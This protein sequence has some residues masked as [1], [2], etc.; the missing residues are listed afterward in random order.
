MVEVCQAS[1]HFVIPNVKDLT[2][3]VSH[4]TFQSLGYVTSELS[5]EK[6]ISYGASEMT[7]ETCK[8]V[9]MIEKNIARCIQIYMYVGIP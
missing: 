7:L 2:S 8:N 6:Q 1:N 5:H 3:L 9:L 4:S